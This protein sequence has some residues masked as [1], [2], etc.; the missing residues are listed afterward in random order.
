MFLRHLDLT[1]ALRPSLYDDETLLFVQDGVGLYEGKFKIPDYQNG[2]AYLTSHRV[3]YVDNEEPRKNSLAVDLKSIERTEFYAGFL[4]S[5]AKI[6]LFPKMQRTGPQVRSP[7][8]K[9]ASP[10]DG[11]VRSGSSTSR[12]PVGSPLP[13]RNTSATWICPIC[14]LS[15]NVPSNFDPALANQHTPLPPCQA[16]GIKPPLALMIKASIAAMSKRPDG[17]TSAP[18]P[19]SSSPS[20]ASTSVQNGGAVQN[21]CQRCTFANYPGMNTCEMCGASLNVATSEASGPAADQ[22]RSES[23]G[24][25]L[26]K[27]ILDH[28]T[29]ET[30][31]LS[32]RA[33]GEKL[34]ME[35]LKTAL[36]QRKWLLQSAPPVPRPALSAT[37]SS[38]NQLPAESPRASTPQQRMIGIAGL[39]ARGAELRQNNQ[40]VIGTAFEDLEALMTSAKEVIAMAEVFAKQSGNDSAD[41][42]SILSDSASALGL[43][44]TKD[45]LGTGSQSET[46]YITEL[47]RNLAEFLTD[48]RRGVLQK[49]GGIMSLVDLWAV[50]NR[51]RNGIELISPLDFEKAALKWEDLRLPIRLRRFKSG[52]LAVQENSRTDEKTIASLLAWLRES[53]YASLSSAGDGNDQSFGRGVTAQE[54][55]ERF[56]WSVGVATEELE[57]AEDTGALCRDQCLD[58]IRFWENHFTREFGT[59]EQDTTA[60]QMMSELNV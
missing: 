42:K 1:T 15:N 51:T 14:G 5:S 10:M 12:P 55:A 6:T 44:T 16:C 26:G 4:K 52:L 43:A 29:I 8:P 22:H 50:F 18:A 46:L 56:G 28:E 36:T 27:A 17:G 53:Q 57:M 19:N 60:V 34:F 54:T 3:C 25:S 2:H 7:Q 59:G 45:M 39:E 35:K 41:A 32:F 30:I 58:G 20:T 47:S 48:D 40:A 31:K 24:P 21:Q 33:G 37:Q 38:S 49:E 23:P 13:A 11:L 9:Y